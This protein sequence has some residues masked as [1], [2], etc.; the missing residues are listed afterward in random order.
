[1][2]GFTAITAKLKEMY[3]ASLFFFFLF[4]RPVDSKA[5]TDTIDDY[6]GW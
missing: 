3:Q 4:L 5:L 1:M 2:A 6:H